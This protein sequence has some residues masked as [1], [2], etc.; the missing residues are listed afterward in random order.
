MEHV[1][2]SPDVM[3]QELG[4]ELVLLDMRSE[5]YFGLNEVGARVWQQMSEGCDLDTMVRT[6]TEEFDVDE[7]TLRADVERLIADL[8]DAGLVEPAP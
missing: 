3:M 7:A 1:I 5:H 8:A 2:P 6:L 4:D